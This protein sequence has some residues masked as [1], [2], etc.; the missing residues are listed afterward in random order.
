MGR[1][2]GGDRQKGKGKRERKKKR[3]EK[4]RD[5]NQRGRRGE[6]SLAKSGNQ[7]AGDRNSSSGFSDS[8]NQCKQLDIAGNISFLRAARRSTAKR[9]QTTTTAS[10]VDRFLGEQSGKDGGRKKRAPH[11]SESLSYLPFP[12]RLPPSANRSSYTVPES[13]PPPP[14]SAAVPRPRSLSLSLLFSYL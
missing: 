10:K 3:K 11:P 13:S 1:G 9:A 7:A 4:E 2:E 6:F 5:G 14:S 8:P 12:Y